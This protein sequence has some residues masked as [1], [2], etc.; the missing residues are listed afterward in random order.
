MCS[1][2]GSVHIYRQDYQTGKSGHRT[3][4]QNRYMKGKNCAM[5]FNIWI[6]LT[7]NWTTKTFCRMIKHFRRSAV[8]P[9]HAHSC[10]DV[11]QRLVS[12]SV[13]SKGRQDPY[14]SLASMVSDTT[15]YWKVSRSG[16]GELL[17][18]ESLTSKTV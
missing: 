8:D 11:T 9:T 16:R 17:A 1:E 5:N 3:W 15:S 12:A 10:T 4:L 2:G 18:V 7:D 14:R 13:Q 6:A